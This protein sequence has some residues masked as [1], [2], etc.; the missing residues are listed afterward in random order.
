[1]LLPALE[2]DSPAGHPWKVISNAQRGIV[3]FSILTKR[4]RSRRR[5]A[6]R[7]GRRALAHPMA[8]SLDLTSLRGER[9]TKPFVGFACHAKNR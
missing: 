9:A 2:A 5:W 1:M 4:S 6:R 7:K 8:I 3:Y